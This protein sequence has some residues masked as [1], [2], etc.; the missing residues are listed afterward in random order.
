MRFLWLVPTGTLAIGTVLA[1][2]T[3]AN[4]GP[5]AD[6]DEDARAW[7]GQVKSTASTSTR[8]STS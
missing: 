4:A 7:L 3:L 8:H 1:V 6:S 2:L 5:F